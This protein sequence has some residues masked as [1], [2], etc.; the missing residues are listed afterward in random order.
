MSAAH[1][2][3]PPR[4][5][6]M[7]SRPPPGVPMPGHTLDPLRCPACGVAPA[8]VHRS[9][10]TPR[11]APLLPARPAP[12]TRPAPAPTVDEEP[13]RKSLYDS[14]R[15]SDA[16]VTRVRELGT[17]LGW[18][19]AARELQV[20]VNPLRRISDG[21]GVRRETLQRVAKGLDRLRQRVP[22]K[23]ADPIDPVPD[24]TREATVTACAHH[25]RAAFARLAGVAPEVVD[26]VIA[27]LAVRSRSAERLRLALMHVP[28]S[29]SSLSRR[30]MILL[31]AAD[32]ALGRGSLDAVIAE[33]DLI[34]RAWQLY[35]EAFSLRGHPHPD[36]NR[37][38]AKLHGVE[39]VIARGW[40][41]KPSDGAALSLCL[42][43]EGIARITARMEIAA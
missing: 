33:S 27:G 2:L 38:R 23:P 28:T 16:T 43:P 8:T 4:P 22:A 11:P 14:V 20:G 42:T 25:G 34:V 21:R 3:V 1:W 36:S 39:G 37:V 17:R 19:G 32:C 31:A 40:L 18:P 9:A 10:P 7:G 12:V 41:R 30:D 35:P 24:A 13:A 5:A 29:P 26:R 6:P 15:P